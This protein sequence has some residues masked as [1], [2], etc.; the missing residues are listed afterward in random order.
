L[1]AVSWASFSVSSRFALSHRG[2]R[3]TP[4]LLSVSVDLILAPCSVSAHAFDRLPPPQA[5]LGRLV[6]PVLVVREVP[7]P[8][9][10]ATAMNVTNQRP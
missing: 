4:K 6:T 7:R 8:P 10:A 3:S 2:V 5:R 1:L 9:A